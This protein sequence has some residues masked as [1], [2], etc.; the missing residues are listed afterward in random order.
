M[1]YELV[2]GDEKVGNE[3]MPLSRIHL[4]Y[5]TTRKTRIASY[6]LSTPRGRSLRQTAGGSGRGKGRLDERRGGGKGESLRHELLEADLRGRDS[7]YCG[8]AGTEWEGERE[9]AYLSTSRR[10]EEIA[11][12]DED[13]G[14]E[15]LRGR[16]P[17]SVRNSAQV[18]EH[19]NAL[20]PP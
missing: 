10:M 1:R 16:V 13:E 11:R 5:S 7:E 17:R 20:S 12:T 14:N 19:R 8:R 9:A 2:A 3:S 15:E 4:H 18:S 6:S